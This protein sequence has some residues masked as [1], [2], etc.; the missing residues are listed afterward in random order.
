MF[1]IIILPE[2]KSDIRKAALWYTR[3]QRGLGARFTREIRNCVAFIARNPMSA[4]IRYDEIRT[5]LVDIFPYIIHYTL[6]NKNKQIVISAVFHT[7]RSPQKWEE[8]RTK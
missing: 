3:Q 4:P 6:V 8:R 1:K 7:S 5:A 2:A